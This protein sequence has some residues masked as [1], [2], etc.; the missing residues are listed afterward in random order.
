[1]LQKIERKA[2]DEFKQFL[3]AN[4]LDRLELIELFGSKA[5]GDGE[6]DS[7]V[8]LLVV[9]NKIDR[10][11]EDEIAGMMTEVCLKYNTLVSP[12]VFEK[13]EFEFY[14]RAKAPIILNLEKEG[15]V[16]WRAS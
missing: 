1:M 4:Y 12:V 3:L 6:K 15:I 14:R 11:F 5:R 7:D 13:N 9:V 2:V 10:G 8:D 16:L